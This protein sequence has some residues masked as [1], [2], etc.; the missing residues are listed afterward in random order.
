M[1]DYLLTNNLGGN[2]FA[3]ATATKGLLDFE[4]GGS[5]VISAM[6]TSI[7]LS[8][9]FPTLSEHTYRVIQIHSICEGARTMRDVILVNLCQDHTCERTEW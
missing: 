7:T 5:G 3:Q 2:R 9:Q 8:A 6:I 4:E 1:P